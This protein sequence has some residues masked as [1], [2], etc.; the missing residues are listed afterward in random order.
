MRGA[1]SL[2]GTQSVVAEHAWSR[3]LRRG[4][5]GYVLPLL[6]EHP[7]SSMASDKWTALQTV[8]DI[9]R[10]ALFDDELWDA[11]GRL[12]PADR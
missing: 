8:M 11:L 2:V 6:A 9:L 4:T 3:A 1:A 7:V 12:S 5:A 10:G